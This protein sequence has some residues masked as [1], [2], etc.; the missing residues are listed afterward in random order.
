LKSIYMLI[1][2]V[3]TSAHRSIMLRLG[4]II[5]HLFCLLCFRFS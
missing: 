2:D 3:R 1:L 4:N 5:K